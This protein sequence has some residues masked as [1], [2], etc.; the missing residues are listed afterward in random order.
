MKKI[1]AKVASIDHCPSFQQRQSPDK[2]SSAVPASNSVEQHA[3]HSEQR[4]LEQQP[5]AMVKPIFATMQTDNTAAHECS[6]EIKPKKCD[7]S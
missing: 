2:E 1:F 4:R 6:S 3:K 5:S 7:W